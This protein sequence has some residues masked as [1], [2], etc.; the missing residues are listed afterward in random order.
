LKEQ[1]MVKVEAVGAQQRH[2]EL[3]PCGSRFCP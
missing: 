3:S 1:I 2:D